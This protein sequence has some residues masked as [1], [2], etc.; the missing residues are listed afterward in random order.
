MGASC[1]AGH[2]LAAGQPFQEFVASA[3]VGALTYLLTGL[4]GSLAT[5]QLHQRAAFANDIDQV[6]AAIT[7][8][9][10]GPESDA[11]AAAFIHASGLNAVADVAEARGHLPSTAARLLTS[12][13][14]RATTPWHSPPSPQQWVRL[15]NS[16]LEA[17][18]LDWMADVPI[19][20]VF[21]GLSLFC[22][23]VR[24]L[25]ALCEWVAARHAAARASIWEGGALNLAACTLVTN[26]LSAS[27]ASSR[28][29]AWT[30]ERTGTLERMQKTIERHISQSDEEAAVSGLRRA[31]ACFN[32]PANGE[33]HNELCAHWISTGFVQRLGWCRTILNRSNEGIA[34]LD[35]IARCTA[36]N[37]RIAEANAAAEQAKA[38]AQ[39]RA[40]AEEAVAKA[41][42][43]A[44]AA[45]VPGMHVK[46]EDVDICL[47]QVVTST[48][49]VRALGAE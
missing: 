24:E 25:H 47:A 29:H 43:A 23:E 14:G 5:A 48:D 11:A 15:A 37:N 39:S 1:S 19:D 45:A 20:E 8:H 41:K 21:A 35:D 16:L 42:A 34:L 31:L 32:A 13:L 27:H 38:E 9:A 30:F 46:A 2:R 10:S 49:N 7:A 44:V 22:H 6:C 40:R 36:A 26:L 3:D 28:R 4:A 33:A 17:E 18:P 12:V